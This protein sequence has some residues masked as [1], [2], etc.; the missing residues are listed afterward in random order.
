M[1]RQ[2]V[3]VHAARAERASSRRPGAPCRACARRSDRSR[4]SSARDP[5][6]WCSCRT[7]RPAS[8]PCCGR[9]PLEPGDEMVITDLAYGAV[10]LAAA[11]VCERSGRDA[12]DRRARRTRS[13]SRDDVVEAFVAALTPRTRLVVVD[14]ITA[15]TA[16]VLPVAEIAAACHAR[17]VPGAG[18]R[19]ARAGLAGRSTSRRSASTGIPPTC[20]SGR[21]RRAAAAS[22][23]RRRSGS[24][25][26]GIRSSRGDR[27]RGSVPSSS[28][29]RPRD[30]TSYPVGARGHRAAARVG[31]RR[32]R[33]TT[34]TTSPGTPASILTDALGHDVRDAARHGRRDG[35]RAAAASARRRPMTMRRACG[36]RCWSRIASRCQLH[37]WRGRLWTRVSAQV[38]NDLSDIERLADAVARRV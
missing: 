18:R 2:P 27:A 15:Q 29:T 20:T 12:A 23:G 10:A 1:E 38:Y 25:S 32:V 22:S 31:L 26:C 34:C 35:H 37:A 7:S 14:H 6:I 28:S 24:A 3:A 36:W 13:A 33:A 11:A 16:L 8:T 19:R 4:R 30:P 5:T 9:S 21:T 17:G